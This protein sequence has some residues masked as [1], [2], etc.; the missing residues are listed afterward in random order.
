MLKDKIQAVNIF[1]IHVGLTRG[2]LCDTFYLYLGTASII[3]VVILPH[4]G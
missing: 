3:G 4:L 1:I 2:Q